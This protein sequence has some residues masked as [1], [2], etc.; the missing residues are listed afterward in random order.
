[1]VKQ[2][3]RE[4]GAVAMSVYL[5]YFK[6]CSATLCVVSV[7]FQLVYHT[8]LVFSNYWLARWSSASDA[9]FRGRPE[10]PEPPSVQ[11]YVAAGNGNGS[12]T[13]LVSNVTTPPSSLQ[14]CVRVFWVWLLCC[15]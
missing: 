7:L 13:V 9:A 5:R 2:E 6:A 12:V 3:H 4:T 14:V 8:I 1:M 15:F 10:L 11:S